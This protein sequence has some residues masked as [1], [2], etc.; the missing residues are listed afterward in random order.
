[1]LDRMLAAG[2][3]PCLIRYQLLTILSAG[4]STTTVTT[5]TPV[6]T[7]TVLCS[8]LTLAFIPLVGITIVGYL[9]LGSKPWGGVSAPTRDRQYLWRRSQLW[10]SVWVSSYIVFYLFHSMH[11]PIYHL[12]AIM[13]SGW[14]FFFL[15]GHRKTEIY[16]LCVQ[17]ELTALSSYCL[18]H[19]YFH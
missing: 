1:M 15:K 16:G 9:S 5:R 3:E 11:L 17:R 19:T 2:M 18:S 14:W 8:H 10:T 4:H 6:L 12:G 13:V 7:F